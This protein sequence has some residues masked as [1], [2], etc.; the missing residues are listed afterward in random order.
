MTDNELLDQ[1]DAL[2]DALV[3]QKKGTDGRAEGLQRC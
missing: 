3:R 2:H 1:L